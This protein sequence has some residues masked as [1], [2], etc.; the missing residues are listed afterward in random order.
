MRFQY[1]LT[2]C[3]FTLLITACGGSSDSSPASVPPDLAPIVNFSVTGAIANISGSSIQIGDTNYSM[4]GASITLDGNSGSL[5][6]LRQGMVV[7]VKGSRPQSSNSALSTSNE[8]TSVDFED[9]LEGPVTSIDLETSSFVVLGIRIEVNGLSL[10]E[11]VTLETLMV[12]NVVEVS[13]FRQPDDSIL[14]TYVELEALSFTPGDEIEVKGHI[15]S[16][17]EGAQR[18]FIGLQEVDYSQAVLEDLADGLRNNLFVEIKSTQG[19]NENGVLLASEVE[20]KDEDI[21]GSEGDEVE[22][23]GIV[24]TLGTD[25]DNFDFEILDQGVR[26]DDSTEFENG[27]AADIVLGGQLEVEGQLDADG[28]LVAE[29]ISFHIDSDIEIEAMIDS[30]DA[31][32]MTVTLLGIEV[33]VNGLTILK[34]ESETNLVP[35]TFDDLSVGDFIEISVFL[36]NENIIVSKLEKE[37]AEEGV[38]LQ[39]PV[40][41]ATQPN[42]VILG[43][44][45]VT[46]S[47]TEFEGSDGIPLSADAFFTTVQL[48]QLISVE[49]LWNGE[50]ILADEV[51]FEGE[52]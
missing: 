8:V 22:L 49:G 7:T 26:I 23:T 16:L 9:E 19:P 34:D 13:G 6:D 20:G 28:I 1:Y 29:E 12:G 39:G 38:E 41:S 32:E 42:L 46:D 25:S 5:D 3:S 47:Q 4:S 10:Y 44:P 40:Y 33:Q 27:S 30:I 24:T 18:F 50:E 31:G 36:R 51:E 15:S 21:E 52:D 2:V 43:V 35:L 14:A 37:N 45:I 11:D 17:D 48:G